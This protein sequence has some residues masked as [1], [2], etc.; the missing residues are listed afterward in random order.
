MN[1]A[2]EGLVEAL[3]T[4]AGLFWKAAWALALGYAVSALIQVFVFPR[5]ATRYLGDDGVRQT[6]TALGL[7]FLSSSCSFAALSATRSLF[8]KGATL[9]NSLSFMFASTNLVIELGFLLWIFL[10]WQFVLALYLGIVPLV[11]TTVVLVRLTPARWIERARDHAERAA[12]AGMEPSEGLPGSLRDRLHEPMAWHRV[13]ERYVSEW[14]M[15]W[16]ELLVGFTIAGAIAALVPASFFEAVFPTGFDEWI[17]A[18]LH[19]ALAPVLAILTFIGSMG[20]G[21]LAAILWGNGIA[22]AGI[23]AFL[24]SDFVVPPSLKI[25]GNY[26]GWRFAAWIGVVSSIAAI[27][28]GITIHALFAAVGLIP[29]EHTSVQE[30]ATFAVDYT[31]FLNGAALLVTMALVRQARMSSTHGDTG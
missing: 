11:L 21:P 6:G 15:V 25:N 31:L 28:A 8:V 7:G 3:A 2:L 9:R 18:P 17:E 19:A 14:M 22:F 16:K 10:G 5:E 24:Y 29:D 1:T 26:Y 12:S 23:M 13:G 27:S 20:N 4:G 30:L